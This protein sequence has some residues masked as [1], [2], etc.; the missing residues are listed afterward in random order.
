MLMIIDAYN[1]IAERVALR[2][3]FEAR[4]RVFVDLLKWDVPVLDERFEVDQFD[5]SHAIYIVLADRQGGHLGSA[6]LL[7]TTRPCI[8][9]DLYP[10]LCEEDPPAGDRIYEITRF[11]L[12][13]DMRAAERRIVRN[14]LVSA[15]A[16]FALENGIDTYTGV[17]EQAWLNQILAFGWDCRLLGPPQVD[18]HSRI[19]A[20]RIDIDDAT[21]AGLESRRVYTSPDQSF[22][23][24]QPA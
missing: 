14:Q 16:N 2:A 3:M 1:R 10:H 6:R 22:P 17:A 12:S 19:G 24:V 23:M 7:P 20:I 21:I 9:N 8:L 11:C 4:K 15:L 5:D 13:P 18:G